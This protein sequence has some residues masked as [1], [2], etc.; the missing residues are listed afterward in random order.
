MLGVCLGRQLGL[1]GAC[2]CQ[3]AHMAIYERMS[4]HKCSPGMQHP[5]Q[6]PQLRN[7]IP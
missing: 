2:Y 6:F 5:I 7:K 1:K 4:P 3:I